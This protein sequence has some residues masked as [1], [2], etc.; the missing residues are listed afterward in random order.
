M[1][2]RIAIAS[3]DSNSWA[4]AYWTDNLSSPTKGMMAVMRGN[5]IY[6]NYN[7]SGFTSSVGYSTI[8]DPGGVTTG[9]AG[10][11]LNIVMGDDGTNRAV[12]NS[13]DG[14][15]YILASGWTRVRTDNLTPAAIGFGCNGTTLT[16]VTLVSWRVF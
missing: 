8:Y 16:S 1:R 10:P 5:G 11:E 3:N 4:G 12:Y 9:M 15:N 14:V 2:L 6:I 7:M 13:P